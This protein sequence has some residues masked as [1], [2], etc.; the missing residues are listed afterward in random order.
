MMKLAIIGGG[1]SAFYVAGRIFSLLKNAPIKIHM[2]ERRWSPYGLVRYGVAPDHPEVKN[3]IHKFEETA[4]DPRF[5]FFGNVFVG[6]PP[7]N[8]EDKRLL[9]RNVVLPVDSLLGHYTHL[10]V[11]TGCPFPR[12]HLKLP[13]RSPWC[14]PALD[15]VHWYTYN[16][17]SRHRP[18][19]LENSPHISIIGAGNVALDVARILLTPPSQL[20]K[21]DVPEHVLEVLHRSKLR[22]VSIIA[23]RGPLDAAFT[24]K[25]LREMMNL[26]DSAMIPIPKNVLDEAA[27]SE[28]TRQQSRI[29]QLLQ[30]GSKNVPGSTQ[31]TWSIDFFRNPVKLETIEKKEL[32]GE[33]P[34]L[35][36]NLKLAHTEVDP[37]TRQARE[38]QE[39]TNL[40]TSLVVTSLGFQA[41][42]HDYGRIANSYE[43]ENYDK[44]LHYI[45]TDAGGRLL[46]P[47]STDHPILDKS[48]LES[49]PPEL[50]K[51]VDRVYASGWASVGAKGVLAST[52]M[53]AYNVAETIVSDW[54][55]SQDKSVSPAAD[56]TL[57]AG[58][59]GNKVEDL[60]F[61]MKS[62]VNMD[63]LPEEVKESAHPVFSFDDWKKVD[64]EEVRRGE[65]RGKERERVD[66]P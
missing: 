10:L 1:P 19:P 66:W 31:K 51:P 49:A 47:I 35:P 9:S 8:E 54:L 24:A 17:L 4:R 21:Y 32:L 56:D 50:L 3:C 65:E 40:R 14:L 28:M 48:G 34:D 7:K 37:K 45:R 5:R 62:Q 15:I 44:R 60:E 20:E 23:R 55:A 59:K 30:K 43:G 41:E 63:S 12:F 36:L 2:Y 16:Q 58:H 29:L 6:H 57:P 33:A 38:T 61:P 42:P 25:E 27:K 53:N 13:R 64:E 18:P 46:R 52:M 11:A 22:H 26:P 39:F